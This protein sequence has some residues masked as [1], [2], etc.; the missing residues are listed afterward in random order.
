[1][2][3]AVNL[4]TLASL[5]LKKFFTCISMTIIIGSLKNKRVGGKLHLGLTV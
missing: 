1:M 2:M 4:R 3:L 5:E